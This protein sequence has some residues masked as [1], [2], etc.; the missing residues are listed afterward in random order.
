[1]SFTS[2]ASEQSPTSTTDTSS[3]FLECMGG[4]DYTTKTGKLYASTFQDGFKTC[5]NRT[6]NTLGEN[7]GVGNYSQWPT[8]GDPLTAGREC[9]GGK[10]P[11][12]VHWLQF[13]APLQ[14]HIKAELR[15]NIFSKGRKLATV[16]TTCA[17]LYF[18]QLP[19][20]PAKYGLSPSPA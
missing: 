15:T 6:C 3:S 18:P 7:L 17:Q 16:N 20:P 13:P 2:L 1:M 10:S 8:V 11:T 4:T 14:F 19:R 9:R 12:F 5:N